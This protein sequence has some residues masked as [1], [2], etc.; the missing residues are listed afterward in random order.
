MQVGKFRC[1]AVDVEE[2]VFTS[3]VC[4]HLMRSALGHLSDIDLEG[5]DT[6]ASENN[7]KPC[8]SEEMKA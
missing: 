8:M 4:T 2:I 1:K 7:L 3:V 6:G 5:E